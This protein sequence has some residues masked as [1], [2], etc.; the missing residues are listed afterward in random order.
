M[1]DFRKRIL[2]TGAS[3]GIGRA[4]AVTL[5]QQEALD[6]TCHYHH[7]EQGVDETIALMNRSASV[8]KINFNIASYLEVESQLSSDIAA[9]GAY[10]GV[11]LNAGI[12]K[13][14]SIVSMTLDDWST[15]LDTNLDGFFNVVKPVIHPMISLRKGGRVLCISSLSGSV[16][17]AGQINY[18]ASK[19]GLE[20]AARSLALEVAKRGITV[21]CICPGFVDTSMLDNLD[22]D[23]LKN[24]VPM[25][26]LASANEVSKLAEFILSDDAAYITKQS[27]HIDGGIG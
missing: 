14:I 10:W 17:V 12:K 4:I 1:S 5:S 21:N 24:K 23:S 11:V 26:R 7:D 8:K 16:G 19:G 18:S 15:V 13:D 6:I 25:R 22:K 2:I 20:A 9:N 27:I 3:K